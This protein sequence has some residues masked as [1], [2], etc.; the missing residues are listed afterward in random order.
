MASL[1]DLT[2]TDNMSPSK[3]P[4]LTDWRETLDSIQT[5]VNDTIKDNVVALGNDCFGTQ[6][7]FDNDGVKQYTADL[8]NKQTA[9]D[10]YTG[11]DFTISATGA[12]TD[13][14]A[15][16][17]SVAITPEIAGDFRVTFNFSVESVT[18]NATNETDIRFR[19]TDSSNVS[20]HFPRIKLV[21]GVTATTNTTPLSLTYTYDSVAASATTFKLQY[22]ITTSTASTIKV[23]ANTND[24]VLMEIE[25]I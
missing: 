19:L 25:K 4:L 1:T 16:N 22:Y 24:P 20:V 10:S 21:T 17:L 14:D 9:V 15:T 3:Q 18:S 2:Y 5:Y 8:Y 6:Y 12:W 7:S 11:G 13:V 23:L